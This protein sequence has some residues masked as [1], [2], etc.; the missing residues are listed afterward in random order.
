ME[1]KS[2]V[3]SAH[4][5][6]REALAERRKQGIRWHRKGKS[7]YW[8]AKHMGV[9][10]EA[11]RKW[12]DAYE[13][14]GMKGLESK[15]HPGPQAELGEKDHKKIRAAILKGP[16]AEG[17]ATDLWT[18]ERIAQLIKRIGKVSYH[19]GHVWKVVIALGFSCQKPERRAKER[20]EEAIKN[21]RIRSFPPVP[22]MGQKA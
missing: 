14:K 18:L 17:Y 6:D 22:V 11:V 20:D 19:P 15:G 4:K 2:M 21:W 5:V 16:R 8:I 9:S 7:Q 3:S 13:A 10:F 1:N 12:V